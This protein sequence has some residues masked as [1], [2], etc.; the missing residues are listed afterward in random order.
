[1]FCLIFTEI[2][3]WIVCLVA[4]EY[5][6]DF[7]CQTGHKLV[8]NQLHH[9]IDCHLN[10]SDRYFSIGAFTPTDIHEVEP[11]DNVEMH[12]SLPDAFQP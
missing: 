7:T 5:G 1:M 12:V 11:S 6:V 10:R 2:D 4:L 3:S 8:M 9:S